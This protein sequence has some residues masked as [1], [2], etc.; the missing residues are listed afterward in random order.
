MSYNGVG[1]TTA[2]GSGTN[3]FIQKNYTRSVE[4]GYKRRQKNKEANN[5]RDQLASQLVRD[6]ELLKHD[7]KRKIELKVS[8]MRDEL[9]D[10]G[11][12]DDDEIDKRCE[13][14]RKSLMRPKDIRDSYKKREDRE[15]GDQKE[16]DDKKEVD[17]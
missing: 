10:E 15:R 4:S 17:Y 2:R 1:L 12:L 13:E 3:G 6:K 5:K 8:E 9:E 11:K 7:D 16:S 14:Y